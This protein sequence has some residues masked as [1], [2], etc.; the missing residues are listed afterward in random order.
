MIYLI[1]GSSKGRE[2]TSYALLDRL[3]GYLYQSV[4]ITDIME[5]KGVN[6]GDRLIFAFPLYVDGLPSHVLAWLDNADI[7]KAD[8]YAICNCGFYEGKQCRHALAI[9]RNWCERK[10]LTWRRGAGIGGGPAI[11]AMGSL[12]EKGPLKNVCGA[13]RMLAEDIAEG[14]GGENIYTSV[15]MPRAVY[16]MAGEMLWKKMAKNNGL[17]PGDLGRKM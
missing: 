8:I 6:E 11:S 3:R 10:N 4:E 17:K 13:L 15:C 5:L 9:M 2:S 1:N 7:P 16:K 12:G 14:R